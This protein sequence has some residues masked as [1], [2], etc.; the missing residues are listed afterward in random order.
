[1]QGGAILPPPKSSPSGQGWNTMSKTLMLA[2]Q[3]EMAVLI[4]PTLL[5]TSRNF[6][7]DVNL[8]CVCL[9][10]FRSKLFSSEYLSLSRKCFDQIICPSPPLHIISCPWYPCDSTALCCSC[11]LGGG[12]DILDL[13]DLA[14][15]TMTIFLSLSHVKNIHASFLALYTK[16]LTTSNYCGWQHLPWDSLDF[17]FRIVGCR[18][19]V[20]NTTEWEI[21]KFG[22]CHAMLSSTYGPGKV[23]S[24]I[25]G[26]PSV[27]SCIYILFESSFSF[28]K[29]LSLE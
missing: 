28:L 22:A 20:L 26:A 27:C 29:Y 21:L 12:H 11:W 17:S 15:L 10:W 18:I 25:Y 4:W 7:D 5:M 24:Q 16:D 1:M 23:Q 3:K 13:L 6:T 2:I 8:V 14:I 19:N 9:S